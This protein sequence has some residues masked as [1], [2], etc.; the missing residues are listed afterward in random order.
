MDLQ[1][2]LSSLNGSQSRFYPSQS[3]IISTLLVAAGGVKMDKIREEKKE[4]AEI[5]RPG[6]R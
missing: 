2:A 1:I 4:G 5:R 3:R 6:L